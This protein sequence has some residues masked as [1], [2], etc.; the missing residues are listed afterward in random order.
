MDWWTLGEKL[1]RRRLQKKMKTGDVRCYFQA[2]LLVNSGG[3]WLL[4]EIK[5]Q[6]PFKAPPFDGHGLPPHQVEN[7]LLFER[8]TGIESYLMIVDV[9]EKC[10]YH[11]KLSVL[12]V[13]EKFFTKT[14]SRVIYPLDS[15]NKSELSAKE[16]K[17]FM[18]DA[19]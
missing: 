6:E 4:I 18:S 14:G 9:E 10:L 1:I 12:D 2:D 17:V 11:Q 16:M 7:R 8:Q 3:K 13:G 5:A 15:F 19:A